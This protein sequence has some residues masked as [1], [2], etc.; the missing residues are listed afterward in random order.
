MKSILIAAL[1]MMIGRS[2][3]WDNSPPIPPYQPMTWQQG[4]ENL[5]IEFELFTDLLCDGCA[6]L[7]E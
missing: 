2:F 6:G 5:M 1:S 7:H 4:K 3:A